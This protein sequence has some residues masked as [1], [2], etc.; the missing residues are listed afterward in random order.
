VFSGVIDIAGIENGV[1]KRGYPRVTSF[2][3]SIMTTS[4]WV[5]IPRTINF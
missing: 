3:S 1:R 2:Q 5:N 4:L